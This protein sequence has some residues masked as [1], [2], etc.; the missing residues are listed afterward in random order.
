[1]ARSGD[2]LIAAA[3][4]RFAREMAGGDT[5]LEAA[6]AAVPREAFLGPAPW[7]V[8]AGGRLVERPV[9]DAAGLY[10]N[11]LVVIDRMRGINNGEPAL[12]AAWLQAVH[13]RPGEH[14]VQV[15][16]GTGYYTA[17]LAELVRP[18]GHVLA[19][20]TEPD[21]AA[22]AA[23]NLAGA[24]DIEIRAADATRA[25]LPACDVL[26]VNAGLGA[27]PVSWLDALSPGG[28][29]IFPWRP[30][31][32]AGVALLVERRAGGFAAK[33]LMPS[34]FIACAGP[35]VDPIQPLAD[36][37]A[38]WRVQS[39]WR[40]HEREPDDSAL[41]VYSGVWFSDRAIRDREHE[42]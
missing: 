37:E 6:F 38:A 17:I 23:A 35:P 27:P 3:R 32:Q 4:R 14:V 36:P 26:Y 29:L 28:R 42:G 22:R 30:L 2:G 5:A 16:A 39:V 10:R 31:P 24:A 15:G 40:T 41:A 13:P 34:W 8:I 20:E 25:A 9:E 21:L 7:R 1:M 12:H 19:F 33:A 11:V 18:G